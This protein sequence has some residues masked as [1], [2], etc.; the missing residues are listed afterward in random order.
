MT[1]SDKVAQLNA[2]LEPDSGKFFTMSGFGHRSVGHSTVQEL[3][4]YWFSYRAFAVLGLPLFRLG[5]C[6]MG[7]NDKGR[8]VVV[9]RLPEKEFE[10]IFGAEA[11][12]ALR[13][14]QWRE[15]GIT[16]LFM[17][18]VMAIVAAILYFTIF[19]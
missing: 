4:G 14:S 17:I 1:A 5:V 15:I 8:E 7:R 18:V 19:M 6:L 13:S 3:Q 11:V 16:L 9:G 2:A 10:R 12:A